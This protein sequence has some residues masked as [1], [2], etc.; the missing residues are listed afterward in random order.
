MYNKFCDKNF[1]WSNHVRSSSALSEYN[2]SSR[3]RWCT[4]V[5][6]KTTALLQ[7]RLENT[8]FPLFSTEI[9]TCISSYCR[10]NSF[11]E[12]TRY[13][14]ETAS[15]LALCGALWNAH[16]KC[17]AETRK[18]SLFPQCLLCSLCCSL[19]FILVSICA[20]ATESCADSFVGLSF[21][22]FFYFTFP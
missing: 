7:W 11:L 8:N 22:V 4:L 15:P 12:S 5:L 18:S 16:V 19:L 10:N 14:P 17:D 21:C 20:F 2:K 13:W 6:F 9:D 1:E 3:F